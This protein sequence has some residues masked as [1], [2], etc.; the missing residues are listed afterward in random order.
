MHF[1]CFKH[2]TDN[3]LNRRGKK[4]R[5]L[6]KIQSMTLL[7][8]GHTTTKCLNDFKSIFSKVLKMETDKF[9]TFIEQDIKNIF[10]KRQLK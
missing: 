7:S 6:R 5:I 9:E 2:N 8:F 10:S 4:E 1:P 3:I